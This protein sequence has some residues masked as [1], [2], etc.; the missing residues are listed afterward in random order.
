MKKLNI[1]WSILVIFTMSFFMISLSQNILLRSSETYSFYFNDSG[2]VGKIYT[3]L[4]SSE[5]ADE[6]SGFMSS[7]RPVEF[8]VYEDTGYDK[9]KIFSEEESHNMLKVK[10]VL[11]ISTIIGLLSFFITVG[12]YVYFLRDGKKKV[13]RDR[14]WISL[15]LT[16]A[17]VGVQ[18]FITITNI[19]RQWASEFL[20]FI[21]LDKEAHLL[22]LLGGPFIA[23]ATTFFI[24]TS[25]I[26][27]VVVTYISMQ[28]TKPP[29]IFF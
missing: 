6:I 10:K 19:G 8:Q 13:L 14:Y 29:R 16:A 22:T 5:M 17:F 18:S 3:N 24:G 1:V 25:I 23:M 12:I 4:S 28:L 27:M 26:I 21:P 20:G 11:D 15:G 9:R 7:W 2:A